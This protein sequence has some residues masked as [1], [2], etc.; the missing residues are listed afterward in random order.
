VLDQQK[1]NWSLEVLILATGIYLFL[2]FLRSTRGSGVLRG[3]AVAFLVGVVGLYGMAKALRLEEVLHILDGVTPY[4]AVILTILFQPELRRAIARLGEHNRLAR[5]LG[6]RRSDTVH[7][8]V[9]AAIDMAA[10]REGALIAF[11]GDTSLEAYVQSGVRIDAEVKKLLIEGIFHPG[12]ALHDGGVVIQNDRLAAAACIFPL[13]ENPDI[14]K[15][16]GTRHRAGLGITEETDAVSLIVSEETGAIAVCHRGHMDRHVAADRLETLLL[17]RLGYDLDDEGAPARRRRAASKLPLGLR[18]LR[19]LLLSD[20]PRK[21]AAVALGGIVIYVANRE[22]V[23][24]G[25]PILQ[26]EVSAPGSP[27]KDRRLALEIRLPGKDYTL[28]SPDPRAPLEIDASATRA[29]LD[30]IRT[31]LRGVLT[32][33]ADLPEGGVPLPLDEVVWS[34]DGTGELD[35]SFHWTGEPPILRVQR[36]DKTTLPLA[37]VHLDIDSSGVDPRLEVLEERVAFEP[38]SIE[39]GGPAAAIERVRSGELALALQPIVLTAQDDGRRSVQLELA[40]ALREE[41]LEITKGVTATL[42][43]LPAER[44]VGGIE[45]EIVVIHDPALRAA[46]TEAARWTVSQY[47][48]AARFGI[49]TAGIVPVHLEP[50]QQA[51]SEIVG[52]IREYVREH[53]DVVVRVEDMVEEEGLTVP[54]RYFWP[55]SGWREELSRRLGSDVEPFAELDVL[56]ESEARVRLSKPDEG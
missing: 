32:V 33:R 48:H 38:A 34:I 5:F 6:T 22:I 52:A 51:Y 2:R 45:K 29:E 40:Q 41:K 19:H 54:V 27:Q 16:T 47:E 50:G 49:R 44:V 17:E 39:L 9:Q 12:S 18:S 13:S 42:E 46:G 11:Q 30:R 43:I 4:V 23:E 25:T 55:P 56:L 37:R 1:L 36:Y 53:L 26:I 20:V 10:R 8:V 7:E 21:L 14:S 24:T 35:A 3:L 31:Q 15:S 28:V